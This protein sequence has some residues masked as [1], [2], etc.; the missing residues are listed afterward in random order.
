MTAVGLLWALFAVLFYEHFFD[1]SHSP[2]FPK[3][4]NKLLY[5][6]AV[7]IAGV[8]ITYFINPALLVI[9]YFYFWVSVIFVVIPLIWFL[10][11]RP[12]FLSR[13]TVAGVYFFIV[14]L[15]FELAALA[16][17]LWTFPGTHFIG[18]VELFGYSF[19]ME[20]FVFW[21]MFATPSLLAYY[22][23]FADDRKL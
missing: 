17:G 3:S 21:M 8:F 20:E 23:F 10:Y 5:L 2:R 11:S 16:V 1:R 7:L 15:L 9:P 6:F 19:P 4:Y 18:W 13:L 12:K 22:E 14:L